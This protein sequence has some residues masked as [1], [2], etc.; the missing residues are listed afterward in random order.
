MRAI[1]A[2]RLTAVELVRTCL[3][4]IDELEERVHAWVSLD[5]SGAEARAVELDRAAARGEWAGPLHGLPIGVKDIFDTAGLCTTAGS[6]ILADFVP[7]RDATAVARLRAAGAVILG[8][9]Q[10]SEFA[11]LDPCETRNPWHL[12][13]TPGGSS[14][15]SAAAVACG[16]V[17]LALGSQTGGSISR[18]AA[19]CGI[20]GAKPSRGRVSL[21]G[22]AP[23]SFSLDHVGVLARSV[24]DA[25]LAL[26]A[27]AGPDP[28]DPLCTPEPPPDYRTGAGRAIDPP[29][30]GVLPAFLERADAVLG[31]ATRGAARRFADAGAQVVERSFPEP[32]DTVLE[33]H[34]VIMAAEC[35]A[36]HAER[37]A[38]RADDYRPKVRRL[39]EYGLGLAATT[40]AEAL[41][42]QRG[43]RARVLEGFGDSRA[44]VTPAAPAT[45]PRDLTTTGMPTLN[46]PWSARKKTAVSWGRSWW[47]LALSRGHSWNRF[48]KRRPWH[49]AASRR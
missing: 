26:A 43:F 3:A 44:L 1:R 32:L 5:R 42:H 2:R 48:S 34:R 9:T 14:S 15:G 39:I 22:V 49:L 37:F 35:A 38:T 17:P 30:L 29:R 4:R 11:C 16:M 33:H 23:V 10:T 24:G 12:A 31:A 41:R 8:K 36:H 18:P 13:H 27:I 19:Y 25:A 40:Y 28:Q 46:S 45:A 7:E 20:V 21:H 47:R 6:R